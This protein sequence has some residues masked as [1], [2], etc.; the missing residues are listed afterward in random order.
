[1][2]VRFLEALLPQ[3]APLST[4]VSTHTPRGHPGVVHEDLDLHKPVRD[5]HVAGIG[6]VVGQPPLHLQ[7][8]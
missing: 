6:E 1:V 3:V 5:V 2:T 7:D 4:A 8:D